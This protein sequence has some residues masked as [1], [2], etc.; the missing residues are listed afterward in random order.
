[1]E[2]KIILPVAVLLITGAAFFGT[3]AYAQVN[4]NNQGNMAQELAQKLGIDEAKSKQ[5]STKSEMNIGRKCR[6]NL[7]SVSTRLW[8]KES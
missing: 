1:M 4:Q 3:A 6:L 2:K 5:H 7:L 8:L